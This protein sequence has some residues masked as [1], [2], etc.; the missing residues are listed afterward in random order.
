M[1]R[2]LLIPV[3]A[4]ACVVW[5]G[6]FAFAQTDEFQLPPVKLKPDRPTTVKPIPPTPDDRETPKETPPDEKPLEA[7]KKAPPV[8]AKP[9][10]TPKKAPPL[11]PAEPPAELP[12]EAKKPA[13]AP[14]KTQAEAIKD[15]EEFFGLSDKKPTKP[16][17]TVTPADLPMPK[18]VVAPKP[19]QPPVL[20][21]PGETEKPPR[22]TDLQAETIEAQVGPTPGIDLLGLGEVG[23]VEEVARTR[24]AY[25]RALEALKDYYEERGTVHKIEWITSETDAFENVPKIQYLIV[26]ELAGPDLRPA[27]HIEAADK[28]H[29]EGLHFKNYPAFPP[30][31]KNYL[32]VALEKFRTIIEKYPESD[33]IADAAFRTGEIYG[34]WYFQDWGRAVQAYERCWQWDSKTR[35]P[36][37]FNAAKIY[38]EKLK[39]R[40]KAVE[41]YN[42]VVSETDD[43]EKIKQAY[44]RLKALT[45]R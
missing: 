35:H 38:D 1:H 9:T 23:I 41:L 43:E 15:A 31:K 2:L 12:G 24:K 45:G 3:I 39:N 26:A 20:A 7:P 10:E 19:E 11:K 36:A 16:T 44:E 34:G 14:A 13:A 33:K 40:V 28:L 8:V 22:P 25:A 32:K 37:L 29:T 18:P 21:V 27:R 5:V 42:R 6:A 30:D 17:D 4:A